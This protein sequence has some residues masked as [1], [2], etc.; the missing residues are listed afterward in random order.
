M[1]ATTTPKATSIRI[2]ED[3]KRWLGHR[4]VDHG[5]NF[6][7]EVIGILREIMNNEQANGN[8]G[9]EA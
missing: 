6:S 1:R 5:R 8:V 3:I 2:P 9:N 7:S 4:A